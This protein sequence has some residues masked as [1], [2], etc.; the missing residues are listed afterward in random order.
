[1]LCDVMLCYVD[2]VNHELHFMCVCALCICV[3]V[4][5]YMRLMCGERKE[6]K[7]KE[8][9]R[10]VAISAMAVN[11]QDYLEYLRSQLAFFVR[12]SPRLIA[13]DLY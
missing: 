2:H 11:W 12:P 7:R 3:C 5:I 8:N 1:M 9:R 10:T 6:K 4:C 13:W